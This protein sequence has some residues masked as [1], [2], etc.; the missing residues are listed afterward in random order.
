MMVKFGDLP[1]T[2]VNATKINY[3]VSLCGTFISI[4]TLLY[5]G[6]K[7][8]LIIGLSV[9]T[10]SLALAGGFY[11]MKMGLPLYICVVNL[12][13]MFSFS[14]GP[15]TWLY[16]GEVLSPKGFGVVVLGLWA[17]SIETVFVM[18]YLLASEIKLAGTMWYIASWNLLCLIF[19]IFFIKETKGLTDVQKK[20]LYS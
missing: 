19:V 8:T 1:L 11:W 16:F 3:F 20:N 15:V 10:A 4:F 9:I 14:M 18:E 5:L 7:T 17:S 6:R 12:G 13:F 2:P